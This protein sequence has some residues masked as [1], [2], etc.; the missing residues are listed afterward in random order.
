V[1]WIGIVRGSR[2]FSLHY[3]YA[4]VL[5]CFGCPFSLNNPHLLALWKGWCYRQWAYLLSLESKYFIIVLAS[6]DV[7]LCCSPQSMSSYEFHNSQCPCINWLQ[8]GRVRL[9]SWKCC[10]FVQILI[11][12]LR[13]NCLLKE[14]IEGKI[15]GGIEVTRRRGR[16][17]KQLLDDLWGQKRI[18]SFEGG[19]SRSH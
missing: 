5:V 18:L 9:D 7:L 2:A 14:I 4:A 12:I 15:S 1:P 6:S 13:R 17:R 8:N 11:L 3:Y 19:S 16:R 10:E